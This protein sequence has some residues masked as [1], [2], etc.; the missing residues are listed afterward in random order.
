[1]DKQIDRNKFT[2]YTNGVSK[3]LTEKKDKISINIKVD[4]Y[5]ENKELAIKHFE[6]ISEALFDAKVACHGFVS[7][8]GLYVNDKLEVIVTPIKKAKKEMKLEC[9]KGKH[10]LGNSGKCIFCNK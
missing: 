10:I 6:R 5:F 3:A 4:I 8:Y 9:E 1:M 7:N 2:D